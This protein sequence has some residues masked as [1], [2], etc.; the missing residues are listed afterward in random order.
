MPYFPSTY[1]GR[2]GMDSESDDDLAPVAT[3]READPSPSKDRSGK[4]SINE[5]LIHALAHAHE[6]GEGDE[7]PEVSYC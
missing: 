2:S 3:H 6:E 1:Y 4:K 5:M 7:E